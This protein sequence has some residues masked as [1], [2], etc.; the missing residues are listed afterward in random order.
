MTSYIVFLDDSLQELH[1]SINQYQKV[2]LPI[3]FRHQTMSRLFMNDCN[4]DC[5]EE[6]RKLGQAFP[7]LESLTIINSNIRSLSN[8]EDFSEFEKLECLNIG[9]C[10]LS[11]WED[12]DKFRKF[13]ALD[14]LRISGVPFLEV[15]KHCCKISCLGRLFITNLSSCKLLL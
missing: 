4:I 1:L 9:Q 3:N 6:I 13:P 11:S 8:C 15:R 10:C 7:N 12:V 5:W 2:G 14:H